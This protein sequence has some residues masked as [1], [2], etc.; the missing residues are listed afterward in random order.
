MS[1]QQRPAETPS[2]RP[3]LPPAPLRP[4]PFVRPRDPKVLLPPIL[5]P[6]PSDSRANTGRVAPACQEAGRWRSVRGRPTEALTSIPDEVTFPGRV[7]SETPKQRI[8]SATPRRAAALG[9]KR[10]RRGRES[11]VLR[12][13]V[14]NYRR[15]VIAVKEVLNGTVLKRK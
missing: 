15:N 3:S 7:T 6:S 12:K 4:F 1:R 2:L 11:S 14:V 10:I 5:P 9:W 13:Q 8:E